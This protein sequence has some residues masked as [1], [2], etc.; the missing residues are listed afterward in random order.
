MLAVAALTCTT[1]AAPPAVA[2]V[3][4]PAGIDAVKQA[5]TERIDKRLEAL[6]RFGTTLAEAK[7]VQPAH[8]E[9]LTKLLADQTAGLTALRAKVQSETTRQAVRAD[10]RSMVTDYRVFMLTG[11]KVRLTAAIDTQLVAAEKLN[12]DEVTGALS[13]KV[14]ALLAVKPGPDGEALRAAVKP[15]RAAAK[16][17]RTALKALRK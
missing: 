8:R 1:L 15:V 14:D 17:A 11:P 2:A 6:K 5:V 3:A 9:T 10:A 12:A 16:D 7:Q 13:G 4:A